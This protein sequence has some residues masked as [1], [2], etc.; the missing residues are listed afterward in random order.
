MCFDSYSYEHNEL[1]AIKHHTCN[2]REMLCTL[3]I[4]C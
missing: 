2:E 3:L 1:K 4:T